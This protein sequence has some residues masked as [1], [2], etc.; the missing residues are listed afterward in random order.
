[1]T[2]IILADPKL[3]QLGEASKQIR[4]VLAS[5]D[6][7][8]RG[9]Q[10]AMAITQLT[11]MLLESRALDSLQCL[12]GSPMGFMTD[13]TEGKRYSNEVVAAFIVHCLIDGDPLY[14]GHVM[15]FSGRKYRTK[16][17]WVKA[18]RD[19]GATQIEATAYAAEDIERGT[20]NGGALKMSGR[21]G[22]IASCVVK[23][24]VFRVELLRH[25]SGDARAAVEGM[26][27]SPAAC[28]V[29][30]R[31][32]AE[33]RALA[34]LHQ[35]VTG[36]DSGEEGPVLIESAGNGEWPHHAGLESVMQRNI[37]HAERQ[38]AERQAARMV[39]QSEPRAP[40]PQQA[41]PDL[42]QV[43]AE[44]PDPD[45]YWR[46]EARELQDRYPGPEGE[47]A[48][49]WYA[50]LMQSRSVR[51]LGVSWQAWGRVAKENQLSPEHDIYKYLTRLKD[52]LKAYHGGTATN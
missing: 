24:Q 26:G 49:G 23:G 5:S 25:P 11:R 28:Y 10:T 13:E 1:M 19:A 40:E 34:R 47:L 6:D 35:L 18:L 8:M 20:T 31:G 29:Q 3:Q 7:M 14:G 37:E 33:A 22:V 32:K 52:H 21:C 17:G 36:I 38:D 9:I 41:A 43:P 16:V 44:G 15:I 39:A 4:G 27:K 50:E 48:V 30:M 51:Q 46:D 42:P 2:E 12:R 45:G